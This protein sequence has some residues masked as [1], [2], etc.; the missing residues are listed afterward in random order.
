[1]PKDDVLEPDAIA[2][3]LADLPAWRHADGWITRTYRTNSWKGTLMVINTVGHL[4]EAAWHHP[5]LT[6]SYAWVEVRLT[7]HSAKGL[8]EKDFA[9][10]RK[11]EEV[12]GWQPGLEGGALEGTPT[13]P[14]FA[15][16]KYDR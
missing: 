1:M 15:Y 5:D 10:A 7:T 8:T 3:H 13:D 6:A 14:R 4:A 9:L 12:V 2:A 16:I 11:I